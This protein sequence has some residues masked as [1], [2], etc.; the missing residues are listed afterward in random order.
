MFFSNLTPT[1][2]F[3]ITRPATNITNIKLHVDLSIP[4]G[5]FNGF[6]LLKFLCNFQGNMHK[7]TTE[8]IAPQESNS[9]PWNVQ[10]NYHYC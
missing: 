6:L 5:I 1:N 9:S 10:L 4:E 7:N 2:L 3:T 8:L